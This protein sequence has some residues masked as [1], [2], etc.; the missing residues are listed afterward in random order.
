MDG[1]EYLEDVA[2]FVNSPDSIM[3]VSDE[4]A[5]KQHSFGLK[6]EDSE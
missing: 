5:H 1:I 6:D 3:V 4:A 2:I